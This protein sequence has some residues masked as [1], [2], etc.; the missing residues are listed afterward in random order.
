MMI[1]RVVDLHWVCMVSARVR[2]GFAHILAKVGCICKE[3]VAR[4]L[5]PCCKERR[6][7]TQYSA[8]TAAARSGS[9]F[10][11]H[12]KSI[13]EETFIE[14]GRSPENGV[15]GDVDRRSGTLGKTTGHKSW[16]D[17]AAARERRNNVATTEKRASTWKKTSMPRRGSAASRMT[18]TV[19]RHM[20]V[21]SWEM[22]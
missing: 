17:T 5:E 6:A 1:S 20:A 3:L 10:S 18:T 2:E 7:S 19:T 13:E 4:N 21:I 22:H 15:E 14:K 9:S 11:V 8:A 12:Y 16:K